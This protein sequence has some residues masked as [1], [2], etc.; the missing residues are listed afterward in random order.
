M[1][2]N[3][4]DKNCVKVLLFLAISPGSNY[5]RNEIKN[6]T[7]IHNVPLDISL[8]RLLSL[9]IIKEKN[10][11][12]SLNLESDFVKSFL[13]Q[14]KDISNLPLIIQYLIIDLIDKLIKLRGIKNII[15]FGSYAKLIFSDKS[16]IDV[17]IILLKDIKDKSKVEKKI[18]LVSRKIAKKYKKEIQSHLF[19]ENELKHKEDPLVKD[20]LSNGRVLL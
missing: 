13:D 1:I 16:D 9:N 17:A 18:N 7:M 8:N 5:R 11:I 4:I 19:L 20:I 15:L 12:Y 3:L 2:I 14:R 10:K 6:K